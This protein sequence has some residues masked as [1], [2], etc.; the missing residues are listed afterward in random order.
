MRKNYTAVYRKDGKWYLAEVL[1]VPGV[2]TQGRT[3][4]EARANIREAL[5]LML[6]AEEE[7]PAL[8]TCGKEVLRETLTLAG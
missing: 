4:R 7:F 1:E 2:F 5:R 8:P 3:L 6:E